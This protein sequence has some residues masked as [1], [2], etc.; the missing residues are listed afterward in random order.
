MNLAE[1]TKQELIDMGFKTDGVKYELRDN[2]E[3]RFTPIEMYT[4]LKDRYED[5]YF[6][7]VEQNTKGLIYTL[8][9]R[10]NKIKKT[11][12]N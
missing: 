1:L 12:N 8:W 6:L 3:G 10:G 4:M 2:M 7:A 5:I 11:R 9:V